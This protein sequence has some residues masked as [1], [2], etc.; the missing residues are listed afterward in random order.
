M[1][2]VSPVSHFLL[3]SATHVD[4]CVNTTNL[5]TGGGNQQL[6]DKLTVLHVS[7][8][9]SSVSDERCRPTINTVNKVSSPY[10]IPN[11]NWK[12]DV[13]GPVHHSKI[14]TE[15]SNKMQQCIKI[16]YSI[17]TWSSTCFGR[18]NAHHQD[19]K[20]A[21]AASGFAYMESCWTCGCWTLSASSNHTFN[22]FPRMQNQ[23]LL[24]QF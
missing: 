7:K 15:K 3:H 6:S 5:L 19:P 23:R 11:E 9:W 4:S 18:H 2:Q 20:T 14:H 1:W 10:Y 13:C 22:N 16:Y 8:L 12:L 21:V 17:F 24:L